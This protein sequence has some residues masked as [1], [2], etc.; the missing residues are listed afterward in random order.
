MKKYTSSIFT[1]TRNAPTDEDLINKVNKFYED[2]NRTFR[3]GWKLESIH[4]SA[5]GNAILITISYEV[6]TL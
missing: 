1:K 4:Y 5:D 2:M 3:D 6:T